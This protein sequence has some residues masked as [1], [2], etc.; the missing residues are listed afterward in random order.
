MRVSNCIDMYM[1]MYLCMYIHIHIHVH[2]GISLK[3]LGCSNPKSPIVYVT[4][5]KLRISESTCI[6]KYM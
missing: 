1:C 3:F 4:F 6:W 2:V 5:T